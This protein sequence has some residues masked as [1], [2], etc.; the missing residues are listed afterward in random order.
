M[1]ALLF[2]LVS[3]FLISSCSN[4]KYLTSS[5]DRLATDHQII[6]ILPYDNIYSGKV[7]EDLNQHDFDEMIIA[8][9]LYFQSSLYSQLLQESGLSSGDI[10]IDFQDI[11][12]TNEILETEGIYLQELHKVSSENLAELLN[13]DAVVRVTLRK[14]FLLSNEES[15]FVDVAGQIYRDVVRGPLAWKT[16]GMSR[17]SDIDIHATI[18]DGNEGIAVW[19]L[20]KQAS[21]NWD[22]S[23]DEVIESI[24][25]HISKK[26]PYRR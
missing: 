19:S 4:T 9:A 21:T 6:A 16:W 11:R 18:M 10:N 1:R 8:D 12:T 2:L 3:S 26:F 13:V 23:T 15:F 22:L 5:Y 24:N 25:H 17:S 20:H 14:N 7:P